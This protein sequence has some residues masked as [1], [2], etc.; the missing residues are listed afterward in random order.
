VFLVWSAKVSVKIWWARIRHWFNKILGRKEMSVQTELDS[1]RH[2]GEEL[3]KLIVRRGQIDVDGRTVL[4]LGFWALIFDFHKAT[5]G[6]I[7]QHLFGSAFALMRSV[8]EA[9]VRAHVV[10]RG[11]VTGSDDDIV[12]I[13]ADNYRVNFAA[14]GAQIDAQF[15]YGTLLEK[16]LKK[17]T[18]LH[19]YTHAGAFQIA[20]RFDG[21]NLTPH[22]QDGE[23]IEVIR[24]STS[25]V[26]M[27]TN[28]VTKHFKFEEEAKEAERLF[29][30]WGKH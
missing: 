16:L 25:A 14:I 26:W 28:I 7:E 6:L 18:A 5:L 21:K 3:E 19:S 8:I 15:G 1:A 27:V 20:R 17:A 30:E 23:I 2:L 22:Y 9:L 24:V 10:V 13:R 29:L 12:A 11:V 4:L